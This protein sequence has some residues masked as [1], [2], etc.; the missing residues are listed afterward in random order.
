VTPEGQLTGVRTVGA[1]RTGNVAVSLAFNPILRTRA[2]LSPEDIAAI[3]SINGPLGIDN[4]HPEVAFAPSLSIQATLPRALGEETDYVLHFGSP[5]EPDIL[6][7]GEANTG[8]AILGTAILAVDH[9]ERLRA[10]HPIS[11]TAVRENADGEVE[12]VYTMELTSLNQVARVEALLGYMRQQLSA[13]L[14]RVIQ[15]TN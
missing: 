1:S 14:S 3:D 5:A 8:S 2:E 9:V 4:S 7:T 6:W 13:D 12:M 11:I 10:G 15:P